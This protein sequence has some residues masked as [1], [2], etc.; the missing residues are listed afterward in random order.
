MKMETPVICI[1][2][3]AKF[4]SGFCGWLILACVLAAS[5]RGN[6]APAASAPALQTRVDYARYFKQMLVEKVMPYW[7]DTAIDKVHG[8]YLL[9]DDA[10]R[11][12]GPAK[13]KQLVS[14]SRMI[15][16]FSHAHLRGLGDGSRDYLAAARQGYEFLIKHFL[17]PQHG[18]YYWR[19]DP[20]GKVLN[21]Y[22]IL[23]G[24]AFVVYALVEYYRASGDPQAM[25][26]AMDLYR[27]IQAR[28]HDPKHDGWFEHAQ[29]DF[30]L[31]LDPADR[32]AEVEVAGRKSANAHLH[33]MEALS[34]LYAVTRD[35]DVRRS[36]REALRLNQ[37]YFYPK[38]PGQSCFHRMPDWQS[39]PQDPHPGLS[40]GHN[41]EFAWLM[42]R[43]EQ[44]LRRTPSWFHFNA[45]MVHA[46]KYGY[47]HVRGGLFNRGFGDRPATDT[48]KIWWVQSEMLAALADA[49]AHE[50]NPAYSLALDKLLHWLVQYQ[51][52]PADG[53]WIEAADAAGAPKNTSKAHSWKAAYHDVRGLVKFIEAF[54]PDA[55]PDSPSPNRKR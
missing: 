48:D 40:Y 18:G 46:L 17:D 43:A 2:V 1:W 33:W 44:V 35:R 36:L 27:V 55:F 39:V 47:D 25:R 34:E 7:Y 28:M 6:G 26:H 49:L 30:Q 20:A 19:T 23:Y 14:Q 53:I 31:V 37:T 42:I 51:I 9:A 11:K 12:V 21:D 38:N 16:G 32:R 22:K 13:E 52:L 29:R 4:T 54:W 15:W 24:E 45:V 10:V 5:I 3:C 50:Y 8:G 41:V